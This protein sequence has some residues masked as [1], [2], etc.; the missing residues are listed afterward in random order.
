MSE[1]VMAVQK[2][3]T[4]VRNT[5]TQ[6]LTGLLQDACR[7][8]LSHKQAIEIAP[9]HVYA[10]A[11]IFSPIQSLVREFFKEEKPD[12]ITLEPSM[13]SDWDACL[14]TLEG[15][16]FLVTSVVF[17][18]DGQQLASSSWDKTIKIWDA[19]T[20]ACLQTL[21]VGRISYH[22][23]FDS[24]TNTRLSTDI[25]LLNLDRF[26]T[27]DNRLTETASRCVNHSGYGISTDGMWIVKD[28]QNML[29]LPQNIDRTLRP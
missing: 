2:L 8:I 1:G 21:K 24:M 12:W 10:S 13:E 11:L 9:L 4:I 27:I 23:S 7:F 18:K 28:G 14:Q 19:A 20:G 3:E 29:W 16:S 22:L 5:K 25:G 15:R 6:Q 17:S 26:P